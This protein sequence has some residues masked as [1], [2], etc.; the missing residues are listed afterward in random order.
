MDNRAF[1]NVGVESD[2]DFVEISL[3]NRPGPN[4]SSVTDSDLAIEDH[5]GHTKF[6]F[7]LGLLNK[8]KGVNEKGRWVDK[9][10]G[11]QIVRVVDRRWVC[12]WEVFW[13]LD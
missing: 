8:R 1:L 9:S 5:V 2:D 3:K 12:H 6:F 13:S 10:L 7:S 4:E 11:E